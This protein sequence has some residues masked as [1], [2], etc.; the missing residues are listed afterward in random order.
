MR[1]IKS[2][3]GDFDED[4]DYYVYSHFTI[5]RGKAEYNIIHLPDN[6]CGLY[7]A[8]KSTPTGLSCR[9]A[10]EPTTEITIWHYGKE[11]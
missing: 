3:P 5:G 11:N 2:T 9:R 6:S 4:R 7:Y 8:L 1:P 10:M